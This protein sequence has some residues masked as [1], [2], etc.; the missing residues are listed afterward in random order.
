M[1]LYC[2]YHDDII[3]VAES[4]RITKA[5]SKKICEAALPHYSL[6]VEETSMESVPMLDIRVF[7]SRGGLAYCPHTTDTARP[8]L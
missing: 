8:S 1:L 7:R 4:P 5:F 2:R 3:L 6:G